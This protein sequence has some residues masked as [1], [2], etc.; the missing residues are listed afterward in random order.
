MLT[1]NE[2]EVLK[3]IILHAKIPDTEIAKTM[4]LS[5]QAVFKIRTKLEDKG[6]IKGYQPVIDFDKIGIKTFALITLRLTTTVWESYTD[7]QVGDRLRQIPYVVDAYRIPSSDITHALVMG[8]RDTEQMDR[9][10]ARLQTRFGQEV[11]IKD[12]YRVP[13]DQVITRSP[14]GLLYEII[15]KKEFPLEEFFLHRAQ[16]S[17]VGRKYQP[18]NEP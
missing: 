3:R 13:V 15:D 14:V 18:G 12:V 11:V 5:A 10:V 6:I 1:R 9:H 4:G 17:P 8:F 2:Q 16:T 7:A